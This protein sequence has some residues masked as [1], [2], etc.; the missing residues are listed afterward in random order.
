MGEG[1]A[2]PV[3]LGRQGNICEFH[4]ITKKKMH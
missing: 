2:P 4:M 1:G 3:R